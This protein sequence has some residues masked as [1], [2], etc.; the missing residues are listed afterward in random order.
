MRAKILSASAGSGKTYRLAYKF[1]H[2]TIKHFHA[3]PYLYRAIL[4]VTF[5]NKATEEMKSRI[6]KEIND[7]VVR[8]DSCSYMADLKQD[9]ALPAE[10]ISQRAKVICT[11]ILHDYSHFT[12]LTIDKFFQR[13]LRAFIKELGIDLNYNIELDT[14][15]ILAHSTDALIEEIAEDKDLQSWILALAQETIDDN[16]SWDIRSTMNK[17]GRAIFNETSKQAIQNS[18]PREQLGKIIQQAEARVA[19]ANAELK[20]LGVKAMEIMDRAGVEPSDFKGKSTSFAY[21]FAKLAA[22]QKFNIT[23]TIIS[24]AE[25]AEGWSDNITAQ[26]IASEL[27]PLLKKAID[28][29]QRNEKLWTTLSV[30]KQQYRSYALLQDIYRKVRE[31]CDQ[32]GVMLLSETKY[33]L[34]Q[35]IESN[36][37]PFIYEKTGN[38]FERFMI[39]EFQ[40]TSL[41]EWSNFVPLLKNAMSQSE[42]ESVL[43]VGDVKQSIYRWRGG[44]WRILQQGVSDALGHA[45]THTEDMVDNY[46]SLKQVVEFNNMVV[47]KVVAEDNVILNQKLD[48]ASANGT[49]TTKT[50]QELYNTLENAYTSHE[51]TPRKK[52]QKCGYV[53][54]EP[55]DEQP[56]IIECI[57]SAIERGYSY[58]DIMILYRYGKEGAKAAKI[59]LDYK[60]KNNSFNIM[61]QDSLI[62]GSAAISNFIIAVMRL[63]QNRRDTISLAI[64]N[65]YLGREYDQPLSDDEQHMLI[66][67]S[68][69]SPE[70]AFERIVIE[71]ALNQRHSELA[72]LQALHEQVVAFCAS[73]VADIQLF[74]KMWDEKGATKNLSVE[75]NDSTIE[76]TTI[77]KAKGL[78]KKV[79]IIPYCSWELEPNHLKTTIWATP[80]QEGDLSEIG[81]FPVNYSSKMEQTIYADEY[82]R[83][84]IHSHVEAINILYVA[85][86]RAKEELYAF[87]PTTKKDHKLKDTGLLLWNAVEEYAVKSDDGERRW[88]EF[89]EKSAPEAVSEERESDVKNV[90]MRSYPTSEVRM[91]LRLP[92]QRY[93]EDSETP[94][95]AQRNIGIIMHEILNQADNAAEIT[96]L[97]E[98]SQIDGK[99]SGEQAA[100]MK[101]IIEREFSR[102]EVAEWFG[103][104]DEVRRE[105]DIL[106]SH[107]AG[108]RRPDRVMISGTRAVVVDYKFGE[109]ALS[110]H[111]KQIGEYMTLLT[112]MGY[113]RVE[114]YVWYLLSGDIVR[115]EN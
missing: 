96:A 29:C 60:Q 45:D 85:L 12:I 102:S 65:D 105:C 19:K 50:H 56:P 74:L 84:K 28:I 15:T 95:L 1:V 69:L 103:K 82:F 49:I 52:S 37:A 64:M 112:Q 11:K 87:I 16:K 30:V 31:Q 8:P 107:T 89:G 88:A 71:Y 61:T 41:K 75:K 94:S 14:D 86:T 68:Q 21:T 47:G 6:L 7:L 13:I 100:E 43:I 33:I 20:A 51:Q 22:E 108:T 90:L 34:S 40:D 63:S 32:E 25:S 99:L 10:E 53:R 67:I 110:S 76:L 17:L 66:Y 62:V 73:K 35:F 59:L 106:S 80:S 2:D 24:R 36:D 92:S 113:E 23:K 26:A 97:I 93:F 109:K 38:R 58:N 77:H 27:C 78:E 3:K 114:G 91:A 101:Q 42:D 18:V 111:R 81:Q 72:Y 39:D 98:K 44:D 79:V 48:E 55:F 70:Q 46:R 57:E 83:E 104:W 9:L 54:V 4:A 5:T 115:I